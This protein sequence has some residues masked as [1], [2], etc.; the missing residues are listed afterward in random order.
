MECL[1]SAKQQIF[2]EDL[3]KPHKVPWEIEGVLQLERGAAGIYQSRDDPP[4]DLPMSP[5]L[6]IYKQVTGNN[7]FGYTKGHSYHLVLK[8][9]EIIAEYRQKVRTGT[10]TQ[11]S[12]CPCPEANQALH[13]T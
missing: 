2:I 12:I 10:K 9:R 4:A 5:N 13:Q 7:I 11:K 8:P 1:D 3:P 6:L